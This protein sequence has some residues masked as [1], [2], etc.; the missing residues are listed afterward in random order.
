MHP[1][2]SGAYA[3]IIYSNIAGGTEYNAGEADA[4][5]V[6]IKVVDPLT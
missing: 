3:D 5:T 2:T 4:D 6:G 1:D